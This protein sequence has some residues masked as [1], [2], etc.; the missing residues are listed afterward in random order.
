MPPE[1]PISMN[2]ALI[3]HR[4]LT[5]PR[6][7]RID[8]LKEELGIAD[9]TYRKYR[10]VLQQDFP[11]FVN[12]DGGSYLDEV[13][14]GEAKYLRFCNNDNFGVNDQTF[15]ARIGA[16]Y[17]AKVLLASVDHTDVG[18]AFHDWCSEFV[19]RIRD[20]E[21]VMTHLLRYSD[22]YFLNL[23]DNP[24]GRI[25]PQCL[26]EILQSLIFHR[27]LRLES[28]RGEML[29][30]PLSVAHFKGGWWLVFKCENLIGGILLSEV[31]SA[32]ALTTRYTY[33]TITEYDPQSLNWEEIFTNTEMIERK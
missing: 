9:R 10:T 3:V 29:V 4:V 1:Q 8:R 30:A 23:R 17:M 13:D 19:G 18:K 16:M 25:S 11:P 7:W 21:F 6:G 33:P 27:K 14:E 5:D 2:L 15:P 22:R 31:G 28:C 24:I 32:Q 26:T 20:R 12:R